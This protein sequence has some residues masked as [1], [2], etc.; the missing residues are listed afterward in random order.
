[1]AAPRGGHPAPPPV[2]PDDDLLRHNECRKPILLIKRAF[3]STTGEIGNVSEVTVRCRS[4]GCTGC[5]RRLKGLH[6]EF[7][8][9]GVAW[10]D[11]R[12]RFARF[13]TV[14][15]PSDEGAQVDDPDDVA[16][17]TAL[18]TRLVQEIRRTH[19]IRLEYYA[20]KES[21]KRGRLHVH[22][23][24]TGPYLH[25]CLREWGGC[26]GP[27]G[28]RTRLA[29]WEVGDRRARRPRPCVQAI[30][31]RLGMGW[32]DVRKVD[33]GRHAATYVAK[34]LGKQVG[35]EWPRYSRRASYSIGRL[36]CDTHPD[37]AGRR[38]CDQAYRVTGYC[39]PLTIGEL[40]CQASRKALVWA[41]LNGHITFEDFDRHDDHAIWRYG[42]RAAPPRAPPNLALSEV[43]VI[44]RHNRVTDT[45]LR[46][47]GIN[48]NNPL[49]GDAIRAHH[50]GATPQAIRD[51]IPATR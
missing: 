3:D 26:D 17:V 51:L 50:Q 43:E 37:Q 18:V 38:C 45:R 10:H 7:I 30:A 35:A 19:D 42:G 36:T 8:K 44:H 34:Y 31:Q 2:D 29:N 15:F 16:N 5:G 4:W 46:R 1:M 25:K 22:L 20:V 48:P 21:T 14:T 41:Y 11:E 28:C 27:R 39:P 13:M 6:T 49:H 24:T 40:W 33:S 23:V 32:I 47:A 9:A 12:G